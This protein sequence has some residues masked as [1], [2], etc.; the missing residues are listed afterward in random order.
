VS[1]QQPADSGDKFQPSGPAPAQ[2]SEEEAARLATITTAD[3]ARA[4]A[5]AMRRDRRLA[6]MLNARIIP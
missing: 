1:D 5:D 6:A 2:L 3:I 4:K